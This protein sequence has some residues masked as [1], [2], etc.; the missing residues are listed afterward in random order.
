MRKVVVGGVGMTPFGKFLDTG[1]RA[2][3][4]RAVAD[5]LTDAACDARDI[6]AVYFGNAMSGLVTGQ[7]CIRAQAALR[8]TGLLGKPMVNVENACASGS[9]ALHLAWIAVASGQYEA[10]LAV[11][12]EKLTHEDKTVSFRALGSAV[13][14][15]E[16]ETIRKRMGNGENRSMF[17]DI[18]AEMTR[19][20]MAKSGATREDFANIAVKSHAAGHLNPK[21]QFRDNVTVDQVLASRMVADPLTL[22]MCSPIGDGAAAVLLC[23]ESFAKKKSIGQPVFMV[24]SALATGTGDT[25]TACARASMRAYE[26]AGVSPQDVHVVELHDASAPA[27]LIH[28]EELGLCAEGDGPSLLRSGATGINGRVAVN[29]SGGLLSKGHPV[30][31]TGCAQV[32]ELTEQL[33][34]QCGARQRANA[35]VALAD[36]GGGYIGQDAA[37]A[38]VTILTV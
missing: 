18:Y 4:E 31:A 26:I 10:V 24:A 17:M 33:R 35:K 11:G 19:A 3:A 25:P 12:A 20:Y 36:N 30:G 38:V 27:E 6:E 34:G 22:L 5:A 29:S 1:V 14:M 13:D 8:C 21:A 37:V 7:E 15:D 32:V 16:L 28:Y 2:L 23:S 9:S